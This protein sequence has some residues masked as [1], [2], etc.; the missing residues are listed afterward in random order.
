MFARVVIAAFIL[1][2][3]MPAMAQSGSVAIPEPGDAA[4]FVIAVI[5]LVIGRQ[6]SRRAPR[7]DDTSDDTQA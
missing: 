1:S 7:Q 2:A 3:A 4:L 6:A 5:G